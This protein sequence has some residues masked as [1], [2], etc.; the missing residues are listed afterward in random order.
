VWVDESGGT[1][2][3]ASST[4]GMTVHVDGA[5]YSAEVNYDIDHDGVN[6]TAIIEHDDGTAQAFGDTDHDGVA[7]HYAV[8][9]GEGKVVDMAT[10]DQASGQWVEAGGTGGTGDGGGDQQTGAGGTIH[11]DM[12]NGEVEAGPATIDTDQD[13]H[14]D[15]AVVQTQDGGTIAFTDKDGDGEADIA[16]EIDANGQSTTYEHTGAGEWTEQSSGLMT[17]TA[18]DSDAAWGGGQVVLE[19]VAKIDSATGQ[20]ISPN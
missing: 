12:P 18:P 7:D 3:D 10:Y 19:G 15:T 5:D 20:W 4:D 8:L 2:T 6:D 16:V 13:G 9:D 14:L 1:V 17:D 11:A